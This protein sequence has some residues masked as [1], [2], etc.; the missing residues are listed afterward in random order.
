[1]G[2]ANADLICTHDNLSRRFVSSNGGGLFGSLVN[3]VRTSLAYTAE[4]GGNAPV[5]QHTVAIA[6]DLFIQYI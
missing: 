1:M 4:L 5:S 6:G 3:Q 2:S